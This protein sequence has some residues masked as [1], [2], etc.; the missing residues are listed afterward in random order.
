MIKSIISIASSI[1]VSQV[2]SNIMEATTPANLGKAKKVTTIIGGLVI[3][4]MLSNAAST[5]IEAQLDKM[6]DSLKKRSETIE[7][8]A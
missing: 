4:G 1:G 5:N 6:T 3:S 7:E 8:E 2:V